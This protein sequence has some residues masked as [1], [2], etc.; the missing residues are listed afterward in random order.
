MNTNDTLE[1]QGI[2]SV[3]LCR[4][5]NRFAGW[6]CSLRR[7]GADTTHVGRGATIEAAIQDALGAPLSLHDLSGTCEVNIELG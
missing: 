2:I 1:K 3:V 4:D 7:V 6:T 5:T